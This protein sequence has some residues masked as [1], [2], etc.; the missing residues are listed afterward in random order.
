MDPYFIIVPLSV[1]VSLCLCLH[2]HTSCDTPPL[3]LS[4]DSLPGVWSPSGV[5]IWSPPSA[6]SGLGH[7]PEGPRFLAGT[8][9]R[10]LGES[11]LLTPVLLG[12]FGRQNEGVR[13]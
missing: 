13:T 8:K 2:T 7:F 3:I 10:A 6:S 4:T 1:S 5:Q 12:P 9:S 11:L